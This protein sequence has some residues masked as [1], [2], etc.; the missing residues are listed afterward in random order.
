VRLSRTR[1][2]GCRSRCGVGHGLWRSLSHSR[3]WAAIM[4]RIILWW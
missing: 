4:N 3:H 2:R 1:I